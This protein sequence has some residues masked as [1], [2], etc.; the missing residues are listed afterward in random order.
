MRALVLFGVLAGV[1]AMHALTMN[2]DP[3]MAGSAAAMPPSGAGHMSA[4]AGVAAVADDGGPLSG[5]VGMSDGSAADMA[6]VTEL[7]SASNAL[8]S[9]HSTAGNH[10]M[11]GVCVA[12]LAASLALVGVAL[13]LCWLR[14][15]RSVPRAWQVLPLQLSPLPGR[16]PPWLAPSLSK[17]CVLRT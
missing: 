4:A 3:A 6:A 1:F 2:H 9:A 11:S 7:A 16:S 8:V 5:H 12:V 10:G 15:A 13:M 14:S 17:L